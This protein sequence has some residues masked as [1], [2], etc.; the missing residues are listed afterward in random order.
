MGEEKEDS[1]VIQKEVNMLQRTRQYCLSK[2][3]QQSGGSEHGRPLSRASE[4]WRGRV[5][6]ESLV[7]SQ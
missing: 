2:A 7:G 1:T 6:G 3:R 5:A 4:L